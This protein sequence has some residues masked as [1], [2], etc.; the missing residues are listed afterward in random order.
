[1]KYLSNSAGMEHTVAITKCEACGLSGYIFFDQ[2]PKG[3]KLLLNNS[4]YSKCCNGEGRGEKRAR[5]VGWLN[6]DKAMRLQKIRRR[7][8]SQMSDDHATFKT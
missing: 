2:L 6:G 7:G 8:G 4:W 5:V 3:V 1:M